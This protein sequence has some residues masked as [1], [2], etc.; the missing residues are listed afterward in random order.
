MPKLLKK[1]ISI[2]KYLVQA[3][4]TGLD[5]SHTAEIQTILGFRQSE[6]RNCSKTCSTTGQN[7]PV[8]YYSNVSKPNFTYMIRVR[9]QAAPTRQCNFAQEY[10][11]LFINFL[12]VKVFQFLIIRSVLPI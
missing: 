11:P 6:N 2:T 12:F 1:Y 5:H 3:S 10:L 8:E 7:V 9:K 4:T